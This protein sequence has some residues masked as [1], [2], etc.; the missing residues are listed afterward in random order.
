LSISKDFVILQVHIETLLIYLINRKMNRKDYRKPAIRVMELQHQT[1]LMQF[2]RGGYG[3]GGDGYSGSG[4]G[5]RSGYGDGGGGYSGSGM[6]DRSGY[7]DGGGGYGD[8][9]M[10]GRSGYGDGGGGF[11]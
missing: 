7:G 2:S 6:G 3:N 11:D 4:M 10:G 8:S 9:G 5:G 1:H